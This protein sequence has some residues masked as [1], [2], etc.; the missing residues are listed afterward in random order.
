M[1]SVFIL[2]PAILMV[3]VVEPLSPVVEYIWITYLAFFCM[4]M[5]VAPAL[6]LS[7]IIPSFGERFKNTLAKSLE[8]TI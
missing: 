7:V 3:S 1:A 5:L 4:A 8:T 2:K 6:F